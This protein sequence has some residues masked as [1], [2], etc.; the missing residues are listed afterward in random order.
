MV[1]SLDNFKHVVVSNSSLKN[2]MT[3]GFTKHFEQKFTT[4]SYITETGCVTVLPKIL[5][6]LIQ[7]K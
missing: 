3:I 5:W 6:K 7:S 1:Q 2:Y 4:G